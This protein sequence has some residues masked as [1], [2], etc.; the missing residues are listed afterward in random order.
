MPSSQYY[1]ISKILSLIIYLKPA[2][3]LD[4][5]VGFGKYGVLCREY[6]EL[7]DGRG[8]Y[9][10]FLRKIDGVEAFKGYIT[11][12]HKFV[13]N[14]I[15]DE[16]IMDVLDQIDFS[17][18]LV[19]ILDVLE[20]LDKQQGKLLLTKILQRNDGAIVST[21]KKVS[22]QKD[23]FDNKYEIHKSQWNKDELS[24]FG[25]SFFLSDPV[26]H[27]GYLSLDKRQVAALKSEFFMRKLRRLPA[28]DFIMKSSRQLASKYNRIAGNSGIIN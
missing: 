6:L 2:S 12:L 23:V 25:I 20:H 4:I 3:V 13:Y 10:E 11:P 1:H 18:N 27:I 19:L 17:Y 24:S 16:D 8:R 21:P 15:Y 7:W 28:M 26:S 9:S 5:G 14:R 22:L